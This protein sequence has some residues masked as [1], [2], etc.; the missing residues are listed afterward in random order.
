MRLRGGARRRHGLPTRAFRATK[1]RHFCQKNTFNEPRFDPM[2]ND[3]KV[4]R[5]FKPQPL[6]SARDLR[7][8]RAQLRV[9]SAEI[10]SN[11]DTQKQIG[12]LTACTSVA[13][14]VLHHAHQGDVGLDILLDIARKGVR[15]TFRGYETAE[16]QSD[17]ATLLSPIPAGFRG[18]HPTEVRQ[19]VDQLDI[20]RLPGGGIFASLTVWA[21]QR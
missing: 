5:S 10:C 13:R 3:V 9:A 15:A 19:L 1:T 16:Q 8:L 12:F 4:L 7:L 17:P 11:T 21:P 14:N 2:P 18:P 20:G 6:R